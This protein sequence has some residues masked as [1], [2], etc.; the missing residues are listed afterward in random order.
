MTR[1]AYSTTMP[2]SVEWHVVPTTFDSIDEA[3]EAAKR[4]LIM[5]AEH[6]HLVAVK[7]ERIDELKT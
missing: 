2:G 7:L 3:A 5:G 1:W 6:N 4:W